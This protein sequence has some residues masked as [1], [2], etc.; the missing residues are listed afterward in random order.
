ML[1][2]AGSRARRLG[3]MRLRTHPPNYQKKR[4]INESHLYLVPFHRRHGRR[5]DALR[6]EAAAAAAAAGGA[7]A[8]AGEGESKG[9]TSGGCVGSRGRKG[10]A[11]RG[12]GWSL[13][14]VPCF[15][16]LG[17]LEGHENRKIFF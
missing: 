8:A 16:F 3:E 6:R 5:P 14:C 17:G 10:G 2:L 13:F 1:S 4:E 12:A 7:A 15:L 9:G 11:G